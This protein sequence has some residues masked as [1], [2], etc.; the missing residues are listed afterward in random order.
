MSSVLE[1]RRH[2]LRMMR[3]F[4]LDNGQFTVTDIQKSAGI[5]RST[6]QDWVNRLVR[7]G[8]VLIRHEKRGRSPAQYAAISAIPSSTCRRIFTTVDG[9]VVAI[10]HDCMS[11]A[12]AAFCGYHHA[13]AKGVLTHVERDGTLLKESARLG[14]S[15]IT[16]GLPPESAVGVYGVERQDDLI[17]Q[18][19]RCI[20]GPAYSLS[21]MMSRA[22]G[23]VRIETQHK[24]NIV[25][26]SVR[27]KALMQIT[28]GIDDTDSPEGGATFALALALLNYLSRIKGVIPISHHVAM[29]NPDIFRKT[30]GNSASFLELAVQPDKYDAL[31]EKARRFIGDESLSSEWGMAVRKGLCMQDGLREYGKMVR[32]TVISRPVAEVTAERFGIALFGGNGVIGALGAVALANLPHEILLDPSRNEF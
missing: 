26:G 18:H 25:E 12:C 22:E 14:F 21:D 16:V 28:I 2:Y 3:Q 24:E 30:A 15:E 23:V 27:T 5:P 32:E 4:T 8:C 13:L 10:Y 6:A 11:G 9:D 1:H 20:G 17:V 19:I 7:E 29:L 31:V